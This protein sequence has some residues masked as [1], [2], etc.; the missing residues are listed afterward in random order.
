MRRSH[1]TYVQLC[2]GGTLIA[3]LVSLGADSTKRTRT[4]KPMVPYQRIQPYFIRHAWLYGC[5]G[6][7]LK[8]FNHT[9][10]MRGC[11][12]VKVLYKRI[13]TMYQV[14]MVLWVCRYHI[15]AFKHVP[16]LGIHTVWM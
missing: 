10:D 7:I 12:G 11:M 8:H 16:V 2:T 1:K 3:T 5:E 6:T 15:D 4:L 14:C 9:L 13:S